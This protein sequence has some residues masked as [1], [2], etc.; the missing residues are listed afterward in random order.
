LPC[1]CLRV[2]LV[3]EEGVVGAVRKAVDV[4]VVVKVVP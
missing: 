1:R 2:V 4:F 3:E